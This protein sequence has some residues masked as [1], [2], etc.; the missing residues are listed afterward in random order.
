M[1]E[2]EDKQKKENKKC[3]VFRVFILKVS[4]RRDYFQTLTK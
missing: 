3:S 2:E 4:L 1:V